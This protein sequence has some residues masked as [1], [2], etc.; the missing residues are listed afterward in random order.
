M[1]EFAPAEP[2]APPERLWNLVKQEA[3]V[4]AP[5]SSIFGSA[6]LPLLDDDTVDT[7]YS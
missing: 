2:G 6:L 5:L 7:Y 3:V 4:K 1:D